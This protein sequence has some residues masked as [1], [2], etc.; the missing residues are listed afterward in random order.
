MNKFLVDTYL[1]CKHEALLQLRNPLWLVFGLF[2]PVVYLLLFAPFLSG[3][4]NTPGFPSVNAIQFFAPG[5]LI[6]NGL[7][8]A[9]S[10]GFGL[11][12][13]LRTGFLERVRVT[14]T[15]RLAL[16]LGF[17]W[18]NAVVLVIQSALL[19]LTALLFGLQVRLMGT[20]QVAALM[21]LI[22]VTM[23]S[24]SYSV[25]LMVKNDSTLAAITSFATLPLVLLS[26]VMLPLS[27]APRLIRG[28][29]QLNPLSYAVDAARALLN[30]LDDPS[31]AR[32]FLLFSVLG[33]L[34]LG[35]FIRSLREAVA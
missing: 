10:A 25:A 24:L 28:I 29:A 5:L 7:L 15:S 19:L 23:A 22:G 14:P 11:T 16:V 12:D 1:M 3:I 9:T 21:I 26:G 13:K 2:Q 33:I 34:S 20:L 30:G 18:R 31:I 4:A 35:L 32:A 27:F 6:M 17:V 8:N